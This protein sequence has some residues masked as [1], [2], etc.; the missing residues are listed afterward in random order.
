[1]MITRQDEGEVLDF[2]WGRIVWLVS[3]AQ[4]SSGTMTF[5]RVTIKAGHANPRHLHPNCDEVLHLV[6]G[7]IEHSL[8]DE[9]LVM[10]V[11]DTISVPSGI[12]H[13]ARTTSDED[14]EMVICFSSPDRQTLPE[15]AP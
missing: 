13:N 15:P 2:E 12:V 9:K 11:G 10:N 14:A 3:G 4:K 5:G 6:S 7:Q 1:M 8:G